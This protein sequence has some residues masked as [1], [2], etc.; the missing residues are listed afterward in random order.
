M[1]VLRAP[2]P[3]TEPSARTKELQ[4]LENS[5]KPQVFEGFRSLARATCTKPTNPANG[6]PSLY[7][8]IYTSVDPAISIACVC[9][10]DFR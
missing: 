4:I 6:I 9:W 10:F 1:I 2:G 8:Y 7:I 3:Q 5:T